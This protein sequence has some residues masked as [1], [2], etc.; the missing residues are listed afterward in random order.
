M[1]L[2]FDVP[3]AAGASATGVILGAQVC[4]KAW[5]QDLS[6]GVSAEVDMTS[7]SKPTGC[8]YVATPTVRCW[9]L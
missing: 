8:G 2:A 1:H 6:S 3:A 9:G 5:V 7:C 4:L